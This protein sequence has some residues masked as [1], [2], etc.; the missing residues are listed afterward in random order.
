MDYDFY[1]FKK[2][3]S[4]ILK[5]FP[6]AKIRNYNIKKNIV[7]VKLPNQI[8]IFGDGRRISDRLDRNKISYSIDIRYL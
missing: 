5:L 8:K 2:Y 7:K 1:T 3:L 4:K 6:N